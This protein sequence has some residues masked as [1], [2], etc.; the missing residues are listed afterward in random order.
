MS[1]SIIVDGQLSTYVGKFHQPYSEAN[2]TS[3]VV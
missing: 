3:A 1:K 2:K